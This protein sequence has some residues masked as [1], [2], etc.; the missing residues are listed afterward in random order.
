MNEKAEF[1]LRVDGMGRPRPIHDRMFRQGRWEESHS[2]LQDF[3]VPG[4]P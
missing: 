2:S 3:T 4:F 1:H